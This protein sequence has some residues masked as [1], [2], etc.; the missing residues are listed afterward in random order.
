MKHLLLLAGAAFLLGGL[1][2]AGQ[3]RTVHPA[4]YGGKGLPSLGQMTKVSSDPARDQSAGHLDIVADYFCWSDTKFY[5]A[6]QTRDGGFPASGK[7]GN[8]WYSYMSV[9]ANPA[10]NSSVWAMIYIDVPLARFK[11]GLYRV[12]GRKA[13]DLVRIGDISYRI[14][15]TNHLLT[16]SCDISSL[17]KDS[18][19]AAWY[20]PELPKFGLG[21]MTNKTTVVPYKTGIED[22]TAPDVKL[23]LQK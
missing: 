15:K 6:I 12:T 5:A 7:M 8:N 20:D 14:D 16:M 23:I 21:S 3:F 19:F 22:S 2:A 1:S 4:H 17:L 10:D 9:I 13:S 11:P 18:R